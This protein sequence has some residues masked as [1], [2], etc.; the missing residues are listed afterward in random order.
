[1]KKK[2]KELQAARVAA[3][4]GRGGKMTMPGFGS[5]SSGGGGSRTEVPA[6]V[7]TTTIIDTTPAPKPSYPTRYISGFVFTIPYYSVT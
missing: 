4:K 5:F 2:A 7:D 1:M 3:A 6:T